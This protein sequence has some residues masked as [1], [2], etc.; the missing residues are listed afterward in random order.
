MALRDSVCL[1]QN[2]VFCHPLKLFQKSPGSNRV[3]L[4]L[5]HQSKKC[6]Q[7]F[8]LNKC[9][10]RNNT[11]LPDCSCA[12]EEWSLLMYVSLNHK[13]NFN[14]QR[15]RNIFG[16]VI[17]TVFPTKGV[18]DWLLQKDYRLALTQGW[19]RSI[20]KEISDV[21]SRRLWSLKWQG[22]RA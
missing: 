6:L 3:P 8:V 9:N 13:Y 17:C 19:S 1:N 7:T 4:L 16:N 11:Q 2:T 20:D 5:K 21:T 18:Q 22:M 14:F 10:H 15:K 12:C